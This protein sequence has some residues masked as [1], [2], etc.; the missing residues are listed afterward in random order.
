MTISK[1]LSH[2]TCIRGIENRY[3]DCVN[4]AAIW[5]GQEEL[6]LIE[7]N[8]SHL[9]IGFVQIIYGHENLLVCFQFDFRDYR[10]DNA[11]QFG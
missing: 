9:Q 4:Y 8:A 3:R 11:D 5:L 7:D 1:S 6:P 10:V 2:L